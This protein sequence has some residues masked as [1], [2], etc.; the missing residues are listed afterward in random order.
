M[1]PLRMALLGAGIFAQ[2]TYV[3]ILEQMTDQIEV[4]ALWSRSQVCSWTVRPTKRHP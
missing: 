2:D 1:A 4:V 3:P